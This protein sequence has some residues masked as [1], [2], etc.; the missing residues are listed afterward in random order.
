M[1]WMYGNDFVSKHIFFGINEYS[2]E[3]YAKIIYA[4]ELG[5]G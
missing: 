5:K 4:I 2:R 1:L 3:Y